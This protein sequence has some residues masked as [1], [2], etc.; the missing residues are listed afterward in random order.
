MAA[1]DFLAAGLNCVE[2][3]NGARHTLPDYADMAIRTASK[4]AYLAGEGEV[5]KGYGISTVIMNKRGNPCPKCLPFCGKVLIDDVWSGGSRRDGNYPLMST[6]IAYGLYHPRC[7][8]VHTTYFPGIS[9]ADD[10]WTKEELEAIQRKGKLEAEQQ[11]ARRQEEK[12]SRLAKHSLDEENQKSYKKRAERW[13]SIENSPKPDI[14]DLESTKEVPGVHL[15]GKIDREIYKHV[16]DD[17]VTNEVIITDRQ[18]RHIKERHPNDFERYQLYLRDIIETPDY[19]I[20]AAKPKT[21]VVLK[22]VVVDEKEVFKMVIRLATS[23]DNSSYK[24]SIITFM[25]IDEKEWNRLL[26]NKKVL[27]KRE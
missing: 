2:Y 24:N 1:R 15:I 18:I 12:Y 4:R 7:K 25:K 13:D 8:D 23:K 10:T 6:A 22:E 20:E 3:K 16:T 9:T 17:I 11:Y 5:R 26:R 14:M 19:I 27:Y 21:A